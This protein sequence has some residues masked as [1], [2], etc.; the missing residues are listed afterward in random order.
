EN[1]EYDRLLTLLE[2]DNTAS[3]EV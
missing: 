1:L 3:E 2:G